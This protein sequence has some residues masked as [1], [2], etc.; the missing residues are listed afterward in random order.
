MA[1]SLSQKIAPATGQEID[2]LRK[3]AETELGIVLTPQLPSDVLLSAKE[4][5]ALFKALRH[6]GISV[7]EIETGKAD[8]GYLVRATNFKDEVA[9]LDTCAN[10]ADVVTL[11][12]QRFTF[13]ACNALA[14]N[15]RYGVSLLTPAH[16]LD[17]DTA[18]NVF[19]MGKTLREDDGTPITT[20]SERSIIPILEQNGIPITEQMRKLAGI[21]VLLAV[22]LRGYGEL[23]N[24]L[25]KDFIA[26]RY[27]WCLEAVCAPPKDHIHILGRIETPKLPCRDGFREDV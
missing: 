8:L 10:P 9:Q 14:L 13:H 17:E 20:Y 5:G 19:F 26:V 18:S 25:N 24:R 4:R 7:N 3:G 27:D 2:G 12:G 15:L 23:K 16:M 11:A 1:P 22:D 6:Q 21:R